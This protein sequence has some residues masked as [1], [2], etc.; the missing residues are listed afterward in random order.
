MQEELKTSVRDYEYMKSRSELEIFE[1]N[2]KIDSLMTE[3]AKQTNQI[4]EQ[5]VATMKERNG[6]WMDEIGCC[7]VCNGEIPQ[8]HTENCD[9]YKN[10]KEIRTLRLMLKGA[11]DSG[12]KPQ[13]NWDDIY[14]LKQEIIE[15][16]EK[17]TRITKERNSHVF[18]ALESTALAHKRK[19]E[20]AIMKEIIT[21]FKDQLKQC[22]EAFNRH[23]W[24][25]GQ[26]DGIL[27]QHESYDIEKA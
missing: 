9:I 26:L 1:L 3:R 23:G 8:G 5:H 7:K 12:E 18:N 24:D 27:A 14:K 16:K 20:I 2:K 19:A 17:L 22:K 13:D 21:D 4:F 25:T 10:E 11:T 6:N 15:I